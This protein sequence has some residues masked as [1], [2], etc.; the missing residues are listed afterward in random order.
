MALYTMRRKY[1][2][3]ATERK[4]GKTPERHSYGHSRYLESVQ[5]SRP[6]SAQVS[7]EGTEV[8]PERGYSEVQL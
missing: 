3:H 6:E 2:K 8:L 7:G 4:K 5:P 1:N